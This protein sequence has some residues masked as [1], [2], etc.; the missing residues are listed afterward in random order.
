LPAAVLPFR[1]NLTEIYGSRLIAD[2][3]I[4]LGNSL[5]ARNG[6]TRRLGNVSVANAYVADITSEKARDEKFGKMAAS[7][8]LGY[9]I[10]PALAGLLGGT[11]L[12][13]PH[14]GRAPGSGAGTGR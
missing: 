2:L 7:S 13:Y 12:G 14:R 8:N 4:S 9:I 1:A 11:I 10:G 5:L 6:K 3:Y